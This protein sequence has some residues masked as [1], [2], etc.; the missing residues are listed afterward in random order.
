MAAF[1][2][3]K[4]GRGQ[5]VSASG[6]G[7]TNGGGGNRTRVLGWRPE[8]RLRAQPAEGLA[9]AGAQACPRTPAGVLS[10]MTDGSGRSSVTPA[11]RDP[12]WTPWAS[13]PPGRPDSIRQRVHSCYRQMKSATGFLTWPTGQPRHASSPSPIQS[14]PVRPPF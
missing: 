4:A 14:N 9:F 8:R 5:F 12:D 6:L 2:H 1:W 10:Q 13:R 11:H 7:E 3:E